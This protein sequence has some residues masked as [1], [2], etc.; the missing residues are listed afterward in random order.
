VSPSNEEKLVYLFEGRTKDLERAMQRV[1]RQIK[2]GFASSSKQVKKFEA[3]I[4]KASSTA[5][6]FAA[7]FGG[8]FAG[9]IVAGGVFQLPGA[10][11]E[12]IAEASNLAKIADKVGLGVEALQE[13]QFA[14]ELTG[15]PVVA[16]NMGMQR[17]SRRVAEAANG[18]GELLPILKANNV[19]LRDQ[20]GNMRSQIDIL[21][22]YANLIKNA[23][24]E[25][26]RLLLA[27]KAFDSEGAALV[28]LL[29]GGSSG[30]ARFRQAARDAGGVLE[31]DLLRR[32]EEVD[33]R[34]AQIG[35]T[36]DMYLKRGILSSVDA[37]DT[38]LERMRTVDGQ[39]TATLEQRLTAIGAENLEL[40]RQLLLVKDES[41]ATR[42]LATT[43][44]LNT[45]RR[46]ESL[47]DQIKANIEEEQ[48]ILAELDHR[49]RQDSGS[50][51]SSGGSTIIPP[52][53]KPRT[54]PSQAERELER[55]RQAVL[56]LIE[57]LEDEQSMLGMSSAEQRVHNALRQAGAVATDEQ[58]QR[59][60]ALVTEIERAKKAQEEF[61]QLVEFAGSQLTGVFS[62]MI[63]GASTF[64][65][66]MN[67]VAKA[68][69]DAAL[70][71][72]LMGQ[73]P[74]AGLFGLA[75][76]GGN[77]IGGLVG[78]LAGSAAS[79]TAAFGGLFADGG[80]LGAGEWGIAGERGPEIIRGP[81]EV[82][83]IAKH[84]GGSDVRVT[85][86]TAIDARGADSGVEARL[87]RALA[88]RDRN[89]QRV[90]PSLVREAASRGSLG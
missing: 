10:F 11:R 82:V 6:L 57:T 9:G 28:N 51:S 69:A 59:I 7:A 34:F 45:E 8:G 26:E 85:L 37:L 53:K 72:A 86:S 62:D 3:D 87:E 22:D 24:S 16:L 17:F 56:K 63:S 23:K 31:D 61:N 29:K 21:N 88:E 13:L 65:D 39:A 1:E 27:F 50:G 4:K 77:T 54:G 46:I 66:S 38:L 58:K 47:N 41:R 74:L 55:Q 35:R 20:N 43:E 19:A 73:G 81:A 12:I 48:K 76:T 30:L 14:A 32:M 33:N 75:P 90:L 64:E 18:A 68:I 2:R 44:T 78:L 25:Q 52:P 40:E 80:H 42:E 36:I 60:A 15:V 49:R 70:Q 67:R 84:R 89:L 5:K 71:A 83:P 79:P